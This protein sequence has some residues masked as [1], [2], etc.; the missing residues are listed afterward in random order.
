MILPIVAY[1]NPVLKHVAE[2]IAPDYPDLKQLINDMYET[3]Y[4]SEGCGLAAPQVNRSIR[5]FVIDCDVFKDKYPEG[6]GVKKAF[7]N[8]QVIELFGEEWAFREGCLSLPNLNED[9][10]RPKQ[11]KIH[12]FDENFVEHEEVFDGIVSRVIQHEYDHLQG[13]VYV[14]RVSSMRKLLLKSK[15]RDISEGNVDVDYKMIFQNKKKRR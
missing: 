1:G 11:V 8:P 9:V 13:L 12:Y 14:D 2:E 3:M 4:H 15:L 5:V 6:A 10:I 7:V